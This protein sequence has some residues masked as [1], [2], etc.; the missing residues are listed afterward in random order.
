M[1]KFTPVPTKT[2]FEEYASDKHFSFIT[3]EKLL[4][5][6]RLGAHWSELTDTEMDKRNATF[7]LEGN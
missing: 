2:S 1:F 4:H 3:G 7:L 5:G 6:K